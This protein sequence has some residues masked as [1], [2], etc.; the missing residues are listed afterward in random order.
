MIQR[1]QSYISG[2]TAKVFEYDVY[3][4]NTVLKAKKQYKN[5]RKVKSRVVLSIL[6]VFIAGLFVTYRFALITELSYNINECEKQYSKL[7]N[8]NSLIKLS[9]EKNTDL[10]KIRE[11]A[12]L[13]L[14]MQKPDKSQLVYINVEKCDYSVIYDT[15]GKQ[16][17]KNGILNL[18]S[19]KVAGL[20]GL[21]K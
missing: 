6:F 15:Y 12:E 18:I 16:D 7:R 4:Q 10:A 17:V 1:D 8:E 14:G 19:G 21:S 3:E 11:L 9:M 20:F 13:R 5:N 2:N